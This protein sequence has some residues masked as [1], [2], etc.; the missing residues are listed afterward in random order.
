MK[1]EIKYQRDEIKYQNEW[2]FTIIENDFFDDNRL[3]PTER[4]VFF[5]LNYYANVKTGICWPSYESI[6]KKSG[7]SARS[8]IRA[9]K[10]LAQYGYINIEK[11][12]SENGQK[13]NVYTILNYRKLKN[14]STT[15][16]DIKRSECDS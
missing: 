4:L 14:G 12:I 6:A 1:D 8:V 7:I 3:N 2:H 13:T 15:R 10:N 9:T 16:C 5:S 11:R